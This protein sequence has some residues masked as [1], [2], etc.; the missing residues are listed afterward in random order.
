MPA[1]ISNVV[2]SDLVL[3]FALYSVIG[4]ICE[5]LYCSALARKWVSRGF[6]HGPYC[7]IY[8]F[9]ALIIL[10]LLLPFRMHPALLFLCAVLSTTALEYFTSWLME[11]VFGLRWWD[12][13][14]M[15]F[16]LGGRVCLLNSLLFGALGEVMVYGIHPFLS[17]LIALIP[18][19]IGRFVSSLFI[20][21]FL[22]DFI[23][24]L[25]SL[26]NLRGHLLRLKAELAELR[27]YVKDTSWLM[28][29]DLAGSLARLNEQLIADGR[30]PVSDSVLKRLEKLASWDVKRHRLLDSF[31][32]MRQREDQFSLDSLRAF[33]SEGRATFP[34]RKAAFLER[35]RSFRDAQLRE[36]PKEAGE[37]F[38]AVGTVE[39]ERSFAQGVN[40]HK[41]CWVFLIACVLGFFIETAFCIVTT[42][43]IES[44]Q[45][46][47]Y[48]P[49]NQVYGFG[50]VLM[51][52]ALQPL[53]KYKDGW[54]FLGS[55]LI[56]GSF[57][58]LCSWLQEVALGTNS[59]DYSNERLSIGGRTSVLYMVFWGIL[60]LFFIRIVYPPLSRFIERIPNR[61]GRFLTAVMTVALCADMALS[62]IAVARWSRR[63]AGVQPANA[64]V[65]WIDYQYP[66][67]FMKSI[68]PNMNMTRKN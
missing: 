15:R 50:A 65:E 18:G 5:V 56:G 19:N 4:W 41:L 32:T 33:F 61:Q 57:E 16:H 48:G 24:T 31:P 12:Y 1:E 42:G 54:I 14:N 62:A 52:L 30:T 39:G 58:W 3:Y 26:A 44:R 64:F 23:L 53:A 27:R 43:R 45:G 25:N 21:C 40:F 28:R 38:P 49:L 36:A 17:R 9:G 60:G 7:P 47:L 63:D 68:Y 46:M 10:F 55:S 37:V 2:F 66:D 34:E 22:V 29:G 6:L 35:L 11:K 51:V 67:A 8:G 20:L 59:W 13:S